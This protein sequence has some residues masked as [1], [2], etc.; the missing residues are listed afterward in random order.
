MPELLRQAVVDDV[1][2]TGML[3]DTHNDVAGFEIT[4]DEVLGVDV[5]QATDLAV[6]HIS[7]LAMRQGIQSTHQLACKQ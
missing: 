6:M 1:H 7:L 3:P 2:N 5:T 4:V